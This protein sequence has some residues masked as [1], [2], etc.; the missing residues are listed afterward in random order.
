MIRI[1]T[2]LQPF[3]G[4][5]NGKDAFYIEMCILINVAV[6]LFEH[7]RYLVESS[8]KES[9]IGMRGICVFQ[10]FLFVMRID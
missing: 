7:I 3:D 6:Q 8:L 5:L 10:E 9:V 2:N 4:V 1:Y